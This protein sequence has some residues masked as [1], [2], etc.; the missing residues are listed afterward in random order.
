MRRGRRWRR[1]IKWACAASAIFWLALAA[2]SV[3]LSFNA[4]GSTRFLGGDFGG[5][6]VTCGR[7]SVFAMVSPPDDP[8]RGVGPWHFHCD[9]TLRPRLEWRWGW[10]EG[11][12]GKVL[13]IPIWIP[14]SLSLTGFAALAWLD[15]RAARTERAGHCPRCGYD[16]AGLP[17]DAACPECGVA[18]APHP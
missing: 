13:T 16:R 14:A 5:V 7:V 1:I 18:H 2:V 17:A 8:D 4:I 12:L 10:Y 6:R 15:R 3:I 9:E 11:K